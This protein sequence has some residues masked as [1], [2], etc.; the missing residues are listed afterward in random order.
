M[1][2]RVTCNE[3]NGRFT[4]VKEIITDHYSP[5]L[6]IRFR[7]IKGENWE[8]KIAFYLTLYPHIDG[9]GSGNHA[10]VQ[11]RNGYTVLLAEKN[12]TYLAMRSSKGFSQ[13]TAGFV[14]DSEG[15]SD[16]LS[17]MHL[18]KEYDNASSGNV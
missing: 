6:L 12:S 17:N 7:I 18:S 4:L 11:R 8:D 16:L 5:T 1:G 15:H 10:Y 2:Y 14:G 9:G 13:A 3:N